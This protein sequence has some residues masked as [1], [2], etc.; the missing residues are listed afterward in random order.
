[1]NEFDYIKKYFKPLTNEV[2]R[3]LEDDAAVFS[4]NKDIEYVLSTD[5]LVEKIHFVGN[6]N[7]ENIAKKALRVNLSDL[8]A[9]GA[10]PLYYN[11]SLCV[12]PKK[13]KKFIPSFSKGLKSDQNYYNIYLVGG[14]LTSSHKYV[15]ITISIIGKVL[16][17]KAVSRKGALNGDYLYVT[18]ILGLS[19]IGLDY[20]KSNKKDLNIAK[21]KYFFPNP[22]VNFAINLGSYINCM[23]DISDGLLQDASHL[24][25]A[26][27]LELHLDLK[28]IP[29]PNIRSLNQ[30]YILKSAMYGGDDYELLFSADPK[31]ER[32]IFKLSKKFNIK[33]SRIGYF[34]KG[35]KGV[36]FANSNEL[37]IK[38]YMHF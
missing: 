18:G 21:K 31:N 38:S 27:G 20:L 15:T 1:M 12:P 36:I 25:K 32:K 30:D 6:E 13:V 34:K 10:E 5:T 26:S 11:L 8:A 23:I 22:R 37:D 4:S 7:P 35:K 16:K 19:K 24:S 9:M 17:G 2:G 33:L 29:L 28:N 3:S 14:D